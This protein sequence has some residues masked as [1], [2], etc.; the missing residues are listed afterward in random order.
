MC[1]ISVIVPVYNTEKYINKC[2]DSL[3][4]Q[5][6]KNIEIIVVNDGSKDR[7]EEVIKQ[8]VDKY[9]QMIK[10]YKKENGGLSSARNYGIEKA[11][12]DYISFVDSDDYVDKELFLSLESYIDKD[13]ELVKF[14]TIKKYK[15]G[16]LEKISGPTFDKCCGEEAFNKLYSND[17]LIE[18]AWLYLYRREFWIKNNFKYED[19]LYHEDFGLT[20]LIITSAKTVVS[21]E[22]YGYYYIQRE[23]SIVTDKTK[24]VR[25]AYDLLKHY[26]NMIEKI[27]DMKLTKKTEENLKIYYTN[28]ILLRIGELEGIEQKKYIQEIKKRKMI[29]NIKVR[30]IKQL[31]KKILLKINIKLYLKVR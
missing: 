2:L 11:T 26:D 13:I 25:K 3:V 6:M 20:P 1:K 21:T 4:N 5:T 30:N 9:P 31:V 8:Y 23:N 7:S 19:N 22:V 29:K 18:P 14:K 16:K 24:N 17:I 27:K 15:D 28:C 12:G 10:Y